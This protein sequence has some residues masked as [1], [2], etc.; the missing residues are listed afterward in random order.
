MDDLSGDIINPFFVRAGCGGD[1]GG[2]GGDE[3]ADADE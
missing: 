1:E 3:D 2:D